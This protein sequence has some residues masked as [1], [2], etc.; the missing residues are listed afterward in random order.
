MK[1]VSD[2]AGNGMNEGSNPPAMLGRIV[3]YIHGDLDYFLTTKVA[4]D[5]ELMGKPI[6]GQG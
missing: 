4:I 2:H 1:T 3:L 5:Y 6:L